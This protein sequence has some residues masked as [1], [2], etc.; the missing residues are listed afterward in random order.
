MASQAWAASLLCVSVCSS[1]GAGEGAP[2][3]PL[4]GGRAVQGE[5]LALE[6]ELRVAWGPPLS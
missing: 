4:S 6:L 5:A 1:L 3:A 2:E